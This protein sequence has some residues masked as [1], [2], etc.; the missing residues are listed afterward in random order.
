MSRQLSLRQNHKVDM[1]LPFSAALASSLGEKRCGAKID[2][3][4][5]KVRN[6]DLPAQ[7]MQDLDGTSRG[8][9]PAA[10]YPLFELLADRHP[11]AVP[12]DV[13]LQSLGSL[14]QLTDLTQQDLTRRF[15]VRFV[16]GEE[17]IEPDVDQNPSS[18]FRNGQL[19]PVDLL[20]QPLAQA[21]RHRF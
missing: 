20:L 16:A 10:R 21:R 18:P 11:A 17:G 6:F 13:D 7:R 3:G 5:A 15:Q 4:Q 9:F 14:Q 12:L 1:P 2:D 8:E 19:S